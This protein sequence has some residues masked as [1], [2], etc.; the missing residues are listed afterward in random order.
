IFPFEGYGDSELFFKLQLL[1][2]SLFKNF[3]AIRDT[4]AKPF[5][6]FFRQIDYF[7]TFLTAAI[8]HRNFAFFTLNEKQV[9]SFVGAIGMCI[10]SFAA[11]VAMANDIIRNPFPTAM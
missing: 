11:L 5:L 3:V 2:P 10:A 7:N 6:L 8:F 1:R 9:A 4:L